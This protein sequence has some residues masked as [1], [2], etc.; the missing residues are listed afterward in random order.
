MAPHYL[1][2]R[3]YWSSLCSYN[4][5]C[6][7]YYVTLLMQCCYFAFNQIMLFCTINFQCGKAAVRFCIHCPNAYCK[8][9]DGDLMEH[10]ELGTIC[11]EHE[12]DIQDLIE[13]YRTV[14]GGNLHILVLVTMN[15]MFQ[16]F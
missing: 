3:Y 2:F 5:T 14:A 13:F 12:D 9:H 6:S 15:W 16:K 1:V 8:K 11:D 7:V 4:Q 10:K